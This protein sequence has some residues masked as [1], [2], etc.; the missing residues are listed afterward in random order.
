MYE[1][2]VPPFQAA[3]DAGI[4][5]GMESYGDINGDAMASSKRYLN[6]L[7]RDEMK[8]EGMLVTD[9]NEINNLH[10]FHKVADSLKD[11][12]RIAML[13]T[14]IDMSM[15]PYDASFAD[16]LWELVEEGAVP[17]GRVDASAARILQT[18][19]R[20]GIMP[21]F[22]GPSGEPGNPFLVAEVEF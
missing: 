14:S 10:T 21:Q 22:R 4:A 7:L 13:Q 18:K 3:V 19:K 15:V 2:F 11:A 9:W 17:E 8:F 6:D 1:Y 20:L 12:V 16:Y 5:T